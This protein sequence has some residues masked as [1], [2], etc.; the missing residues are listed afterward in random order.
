MAGVSAILA[1]PDMRGRP[2]GEHG[3]LAAVL[4]PGMR[5]VSVSV[6]QISDI[7]GFVRLSIT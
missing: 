6:D 2:S 1:D 7:S 5:P 3:F 4:L